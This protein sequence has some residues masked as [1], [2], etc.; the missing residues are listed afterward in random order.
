[1][2]PFPVNS[3]AQVAALAALNDEDHAI[4]SIQLVYEGSGTFI[5]N[6]IRWDSPMFPVSN[7]I[8]IDFERFGRGQALLKKGIIIRPGKT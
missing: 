1:V 5:K 3:L 6:W 2:R 8:F 7:F 4:K